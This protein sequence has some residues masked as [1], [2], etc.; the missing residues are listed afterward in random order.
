M[1]DA[2]ES[3]YPAK[4]NRRNRLDI[5]SLRGEESKDQ[6][7]KGI[8]SDESAFIPRLIRNSVQT[9]SAVEDGVVGLTSPTRR[10]TK[11]VD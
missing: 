9:L 4:L 7:E 2:R 10:A 1:P 6:H 8:C 3:F 11:H 5:L